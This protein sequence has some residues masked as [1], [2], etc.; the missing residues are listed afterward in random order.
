MQISIIATMSKNSQR[1]ENVRIAH[2]EHVCPTCNSSIDMFKSADGSILFHKI[3]VLVF[4]TERNHE[5]QKHLTK[6][7]LCRDLYEH[8]SSAVTFMSNTQQRHGAESS[9]Q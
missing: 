8:E 3:H 9:H 7:S 1:Y 2:G 5:F 6:D 4:D